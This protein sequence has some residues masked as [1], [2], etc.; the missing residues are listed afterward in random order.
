MLLRVLVILVVALVSCWAVLAVGLNFMGIDLYWP[1]Y[2]ADK[3]Q[4]PHHRLLAARNGVFLTFAFYGFMFLRNSFEKVYP[5]HFLKVYLLMTTI[6]GALVLIKIELY[7]FD[8]ITSLLMLPLCALVIHLG[9]R[10]NY[11]RYFTGGSDEPF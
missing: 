7:S 3:E 6:A 5:I 11:R 2:L 4:I 1:F 9:S 8:E 10:L